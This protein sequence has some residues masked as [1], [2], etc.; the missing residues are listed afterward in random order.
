VKKYVSAGVDAVI[1][2]SANLKI[3]E[4]T[5]SSKLQNKIAEYTKKLKRSTRI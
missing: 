3:I 5:S 4:N 1:V 2:G